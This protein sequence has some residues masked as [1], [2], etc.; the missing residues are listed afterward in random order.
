MV[1]WA[2]LFSVMNV[3]DGK[4]LVPSLMWFWSLPSAQHGNWDKLMDWCTDQLIN[5][6]IISSNGS[7]IPPGAPELRGLK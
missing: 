4:R 3:C 1:G 5:E 7:T 6:A 2:G